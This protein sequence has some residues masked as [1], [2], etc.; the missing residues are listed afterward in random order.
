MPSQVVQSGE[1]TLELDTGFTVNGFTLDNPTSGVLDNTL[2]VLDGTTQFADIT[3]Y[4]T[5]VSYTRGRRKTDYQFGAGMM[6]FTMID[7]TGILGPYDSTSPYYDPANQEPGLAPM[8]QVRLKRENTYIFTG[9]VMG[10]DYEFAKAG[11]NTVNVQCADDFYK[12]AQTQMAALNPSPELSGARINTVLA[13][14]EVDYNGTTDIDPGTVSIGHD[15]AYDVDAGTNTLAYLQQINQAEQGRL[16]MAADGELVFQPRIGNTLQAPTVE[17]T[18]NGTGTKYTDLAIAFDADDVINRVYI[19]ALDGKTAT[20]TDAASIAKYFTQS[21]SITNSLLHDQSEID[22]LA[23][24]LLEPEP[25]PRY[26]SLTTTY[27]RLTE[28][29]RDDV[30][31]L[32]IG[33]TISITKDIP[34]LL[35]PIESTL[36]IEGIQGNINVTNGH[37]ITF[38]TSAAALVY[39]LILDD[40]IYGKLDSNNAVA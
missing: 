23:A 32:D 19:Q 24:Y 7:E 15:S 31:A 30:T 29:E 22:D 36:S 8:R 12:L 40:A 16:F 26:T 39:A 13:L 9:T 37:T 5:N 4:V 25:A 1:Y 27:S 20:D 3:E 10:Y 17:F 14:P 33:D 11:Y 18:D 38:Y 21:L 34:N 28:A 35:T 6:N 2:F